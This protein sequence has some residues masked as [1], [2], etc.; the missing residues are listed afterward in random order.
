MIDSIFH[1]AQDR[2]QDTPGVT[3]TL[4]QAFP[5]CAASAPAAQ[6]ALNLRPAS[7]LNAESTIQPERVFELS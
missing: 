1:A 6:R 4:A 2:A 7:T 3:I 5:A